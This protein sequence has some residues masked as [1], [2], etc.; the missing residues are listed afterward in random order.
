MSEWQPKRRSR[1]T[2]PHIKSMRAIVRGFERIEALGEHDLR[3]ALNYV[4]DRFY[5]S[6]LHKKI[7]PLAASEGT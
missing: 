5:K 6:L 4:N 2:D 7:Q 1:K 3:A